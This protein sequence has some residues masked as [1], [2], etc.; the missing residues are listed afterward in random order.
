VVKAKQSY[1]KLLGS[2][3]AHGKYL[4]RDV[5]RSGDGFSK[6]ED[7]VQIPKLLH[8][9]Q[10]EG[11]E[12]LHK[13]ILSPEYAERIDLKSHAREVMIQMEHDLKRPIEWV[14]IL[15]KNTDNHHVHISLRGIDRSGKKL[16]IEEYLGSS[17]RE[18]SQE[19]VTKKLGPR[20]YPEIQR[21]RETEIFARRV[22]DIDRSLLWKADAHSIVR[23]SEKVSSDWRRNN[24]R[25]QERIRIAFLTGLGLAKRI[26]N[27]SWS[28]SPTLR[29]SLK[30]LGLREQIIKEQ[31]PG[32]EFVRTLRNGGV[33][34]KRLELG[35]SLTGRL[36]AVGIK[37]PFGDRRFMLLE[38]TDGV[39][40]HI[41]EPRGVVSTK[42]APDQVVT[43]TRR[44]AAIRDEKNKRTE[45]REFTAVEFH[46]DWR[47]SL[48]L[49]Y[50]AAAMLRDSTL[51]ASKAKRIG[52]ASQ[53]HEAV[54]ERIASL[55]KSKFNPQSPTWK[56]D[57]GTLRF[58]EADRQARHW[59]PRDSAEASTLH[60]ANGPNLIVG[61]IRTVSDGRILVQDIRTGSGWIVRIKDVGLD[62]PPSVGTMV[63]LEVKPIPHVG[64]RPADERIASLFASTGTINQTALTSDEK[65]FVLARIRTWVRWGVLKEVEPGVYR[66]VD[67]ASEQN[68]G[69]VLERMET[70]LSEMRVNLA[71]AKRQPAWLKTLDEADLRRPGL[72]FGPLESLLRDAGPILENSQSDWLSKLLKER[73]ATWRQ[74]GVKIDRDFER[75][76]KSWLNSAEAK[77][78]IK[79]TFNARTKDRSDE[80][81]L[82]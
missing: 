13:I 24:S 17:L 77:N 52:F 23:I 38:G 18:R 72:R 70:K 6:T 61:E 57:L 37:D 71:D 20:L 5:A 9:W 39:I 49:D 19:L 34:R 69:H 78:L 3:R 65:T 10:K 33:V 80:R 59:N 25:E 53:W 60:K 46:A 50:Q 16:D 22:T 67:I 21:Q 42:T 43:L 1:Q 62:W 40:Y 48:A 30:Q 36:I 15:H 63:R 41:N 73:Q 2:W 76:A 47:K 8:Q 4:E 35:E 27:E 81:T 14:A 7:S 56:T 66:P 55:G 51:G 31:I 12:K 28:L 68:K 11:D 32:W 74:H 54:G 45:H 44:I 64:L 29:E 79:E 58:I 26:S 82:E 75:N